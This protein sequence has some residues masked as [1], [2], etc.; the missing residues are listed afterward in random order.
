M[1]ALPD[2]TPAIPYRQT[3]PV[4]SV[5]DAASMLQLSE[6]TVLRLV[7]DKAITGRQVGVVW[8]LKLADVE[9]LLPNT[10][11]SPPLEIA[12]AQLPALSPDERRQ[13]AREALDY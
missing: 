8:R 4:C 1:T 2:I 7:R 11:E 9:A 3:V 12:R 10:P 6:R 13:L 5:K